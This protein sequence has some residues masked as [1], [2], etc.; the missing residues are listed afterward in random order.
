MSEQNKIWWWQHL[1]E[2]ERNLLIE[3]RE[4]LER[5]ADRIQNLQNEGC[6]ITES[7]VFEIMRQEMGEK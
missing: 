3:N 6:N 5:V 1:R 4:A 2:E 7:E